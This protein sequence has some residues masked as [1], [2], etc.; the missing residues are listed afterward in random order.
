MCIMGKQK[1][2]KEGGR[3]N[4]RRVTAEITCAGV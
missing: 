2:V 1:G 4:K 3:A